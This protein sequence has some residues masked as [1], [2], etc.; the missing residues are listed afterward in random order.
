MLAHGAGKAV[1][2]LYSND[3]TQTPGLPAPRQTQA[4]YPDK[5]P[6]FSGNRQLHYGKSR[7]RAPLSALATWTHAEATLKPT[8][9]PQ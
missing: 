5:T 1:N 2:L 7:C 6:D 8:A 3:R 9:K 4:C